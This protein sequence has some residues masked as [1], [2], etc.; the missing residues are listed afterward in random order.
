[1]PKTPPLAIVPDRPPAASAT[2]DGPPAA[3]GETGRDLW[4]RVMAEY[5]VADCGGRELLYQACAAVDRLAAIS[6]RISEDGEVL[7]TKG[8]LK[9]HPSIRDEIQLRAFVVRTIA[10][11]GLD[12]EP[13]RGGVGRPGGESSGWRG[14]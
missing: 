3:L 7:K 1:M 2:T 4:N 11:L 8:G 6:A 12:V 10:K 9:S 5:A 14:E 13:L